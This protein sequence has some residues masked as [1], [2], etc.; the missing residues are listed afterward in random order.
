MEIYFG[1]LNVEEGNELGRLRAVEELAEV[2]GEVEG[3]G[4]GESGVP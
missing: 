1:C 3:G 4:G 2:V